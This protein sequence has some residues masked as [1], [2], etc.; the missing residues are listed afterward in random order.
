MTERRYGVPTPIPPEETA[1]LQGAAV[2][3]RELGEGRVVFI[4]ESGRCLRVAFAEREIY[5]SYPEA[6]ERRGFSG[7]ALTL[8]DEAKGAQAEAHA[9]RED[10]HFYRSHM[11]TDP[12][13]MEPCYQRVEASVTAAARRRVGPHLF[14]GACHKIWGEKRRLLLERHGIAWMSP[15]AMNPDTLFD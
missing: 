7:S 2:R 10:L 12:I 6:F 15:S 14:M 4:S 3:H 5:F 8:A 11:R 9:A 1:Y 13:E